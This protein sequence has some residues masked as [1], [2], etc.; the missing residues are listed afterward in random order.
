M[1]SL[2]V[3][4]KTRPAVQARILQT[5]LNYN[6]LKAAGGPMTPKLTVIIKSLQRTTRALLRFVM[7]IMPQ[8]PLAERV[9]LYLRRLQSSTTA[10]FAQA[11]AV[12]RPAEQMNDNTK[13]QKIEA[14]KRFPPMPPPPHSYAQLFTLV[15]NPEF[16]QFDVSLLSEDIVSA[17]SSALMQHIDS[18]SLDEAVEEVQ[19]RLQR[20]QDMA[21][22]SAAASA[23][24]DDDYDPEALSGAEGPTDRTL[25]QMGEPL[26]QPTLELGPFEL[27]KPDPLTDMELAMLSEQSIAHVFETALI[28]EQN[29][30]LVKAKL[31][32]NRLA[33][34]ANDKDSW[35]TLMIRLATRAPAGLN[36]LAALNNEADQLQQPDT[37]ESLESLTV[38]NR[39]RRQLFDYILDDWKHRLALGITWLTEEW[40][41]DKIQAVGMTNGSVATTKPNPATSHYD[42]WATRLLE[43]LIPRFDKDDHRI[44]IRFLSE[45]PAINRNILAQVKTL[46]RDPA[47]VDICK[48]ALQ[49]LYLMRP[50]VRELVIDTMEDIYK[51]GDDEV[52]N[53]VGQ[54]IQKWR[55]GFM[56]PK[57][58]QT[59]KEAEETR[60]V[61]NGVKAEEISR[62]DSTQT[63]TEVT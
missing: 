7:R 56:D 46:T 29:N 31:G 3:L 34:S 23:D 25:E 42:Y 32:V 36:T 55:P 58:E 27:P 37:Y 50:P 18:K 53:T 1:N 6:P 28:A 8:H 14:V 26:L 38:P 60:T 21:K 39:I 33:G 13:R 11:Q 10:V 54:L 51:E 15:E 40:Y 49:Y 22:A 20:I 59:R 17:L 63:S 30:G 43:T 12:K 16:Q 19:L 45:I 4:L 35:L 52:K 62:P 5:V 2:A 47:T 41:A 57:A 44:L 61:P 24:E 48:K 9:D